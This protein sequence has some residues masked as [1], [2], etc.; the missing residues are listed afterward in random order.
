MWQNTFNQGNKY[1][2]CSNGVN[3][4][5]DER[6]DHIIQLICLISLFYDNVLNVTLTTGKGPLIDFLL[7]GRRLIK[8]LQYLFLRHLPDD[9]SSTLVHWDQLAYQALEPLVPEERQQQQVILDLH[10]PL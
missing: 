3:I 2:D 10:T 6:A 7:E 1:F 9:T 5:T 8:S 4:T